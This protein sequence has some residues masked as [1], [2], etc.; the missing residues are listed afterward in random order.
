MAD[1]S[2]D[3]NNNATTM[4]DATEDS[5]LLERGTD[6]NPLLDD[7]DEPQ[8]A[9]G[10]EASDD[11]NDEALIREEWL[12]QLR[13]IQTM[14]CFVSHG[15]SVLGVILVLVW[16]HLL[17]GLSWK[18]GESKKVFNWHPLLMIVAFCFMTVASLS[19]RFPLRSNNRWTT[20]FVHGAAW[21]VA[22]ISAFIALLAVFKSH[23]DKVSGFIANLYSLHSW[24]GMGVIGLY[25]V[26]FLAGFFSFGM[27]VTSR[28]QRAKLLTLHSFLGP[29][30]YVAMTATVLLGIQEKEGFVK[31]GY[32]VDKADT[33]P[34]SHLGQI[35]P[36][37][38]VSH[39]LGIV[40]LGTALCT[41][42]ALH[43]F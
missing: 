21:F 9:Q 38:L 43:N 18:E 20:K 26:Q 29:F 12:M 34:L 5:D 27:Q 1:I 30:I 22:G 39:I 33:F 41:I 24:I 3:S 7:N 10:V 23:N 8:H 25:V 31:C 2:Q 4:Q 13:R 35:P 36:A 11:G 40:V 15:L 17:G 42:F 16:V 19:F 32:T 14:A 6:E 37:C 28:T